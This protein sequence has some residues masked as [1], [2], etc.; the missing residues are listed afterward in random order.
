[1]RF[2]ATLAVAAVVATPLAAQDDFSWR[3]RIARGDAIE[4]RGVNGDVSAEFTSGDEVQVTAVKRWR[5]SDPDDVRIEVVEHSGGVTICA[6]YPSDGRRENECRPGGGRNNVNDNDVSVHFTVRVPAGVAF[7]G[8]TVNGEVDVNDLESDVFVGTV[9]GS[10]DVSTTGMAEATTVNGSIRASMGRADWSGTMEF[11]TVNGGITL[12]VP[13][14]F[15]A[16]VEASTVNGDMESDFP[17]TVRGRFNNRRFR[18]TIGDGG[19]SL[20]LRTVNG[21]I[22]LLRRG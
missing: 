3:G 22:R 4:I 13:D 8:H 12:E 14:G 18:G 5:R 17:L 16:D 10:V 6:V 7:E 1:M 20:E 15:G 2:L 9:N 19:R 21:D 11:S